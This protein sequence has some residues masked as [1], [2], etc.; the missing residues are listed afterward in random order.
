MRKYIIP[1]I[2]PFIEKLR[3]IDYRISK[4]IEEGVLRKAGE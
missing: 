1:K 4:D 3:Q 2:R